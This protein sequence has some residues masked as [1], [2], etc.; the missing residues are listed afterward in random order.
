[1]VA[2]LTER[3]TLPVADGTSMNAYVSCPENATSLPA[4]AVFQEAFGVNAHIRDVA[5]RLAGLGMMAIAPELFHRSGPG[6]EGR[7]DDFP[8]VREHMGALTR[9]GLEADIDATYAWMRD[10]SRCDPETLSAIGFCMGGRVAYMANS[11]TVLRAAISFYGGG[12]APDLVPLA[13][14]QRG[15]I[16]MFWGG[17]DKHIPPEQYRTVSDALAAAN[18]TQEQVVFGQADHGFF[19]DKRASYNPIA[20]KQAWA[21]VQEFLACYGVLH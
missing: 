4:I 13:Q 20:A 5:D 16:L 6:F 3:V 2:L 14:T 21:L 19:C 12:I 9:E 7:Y 10:E 11:R 15:P 17:Q 18:V 1:M 8:A